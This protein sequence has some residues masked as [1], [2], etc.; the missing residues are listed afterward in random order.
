MDRAL[1]DG[2]NKACSYRQITTL[3]INLITPTLRN[4]FPTPATFLTIKGLTKGRY[5]LTVGAHHIKQGSSSATSGGAI[6]ADWTETAVSAAKDYTVTFDVLTDEVT[7]G[8]KTTNSTANWMACDNFRLSLIS[9]DVSYMR[10]GLTN[11]ITVARSLASQSMDSNVKSALESAINHASSLTSNGTASQ[12]QAA[13]ST[14]KTSMLN[15]E[16]SIFATNVSTSGTVPTVITDTR[17]ARGATMIFGRSTVTSSASVKE[18]GFCY[19][20]TN[21]VP[22]VADERTSRYVENGGPI[23]CLDNL[24]P[25]TLYY[26]RAY[27]TTT[28]GKVGYGDVLKVYTLPLG[29]DSRYREACTIGSNLQVSADSTLVPTM[30]RV[31]VQAVEQPTAAMEDG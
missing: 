25:A 1:P 10:T 22:T 13:A 6:F 26:I 8:F 9:T 29:K 12:I 31:P 23:Y 24:H 11:L 7:I 14:L 15:A 27:A 16:R 2:S 18:K 5:R 3:H 19:S 30:S 4:G 20:T 21:P 28:T 17:Y